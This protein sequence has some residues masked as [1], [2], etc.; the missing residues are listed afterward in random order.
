MWLVAALHCTLSLSFVHLVRSSSSE[1][2][3]YKILHIPVNHDRY[4]HYYEKEKI[5][6]VS[7]DHGYQGSYHT[8]SSSSSTSP[9]QFSSQISIRRESTVNQLPY[10][11][12]KCK[13]LADDFIVEM[14]VDGS[15][16]DPR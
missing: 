16:E 1:S 3:T 11:V 14:N 10:F 13:S 6:N 8:Q 15:D 5:D 12:T 9:E 2:R 4:I 7:C